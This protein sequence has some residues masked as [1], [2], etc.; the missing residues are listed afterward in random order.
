[1][2]EPSILHRCRL[3]SDHTPTGRTRHLAGG[4]VLP[5]PSELRIVQYLNDPGYYL[6]YCDDTGKELTDTYH[7]SVEG[8]MAQAE[9]E[10]EVGKH[11]WES[12]P[13]AGGS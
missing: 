6:F 9:W 5:A 2:N 4:E 3:T 8:A 1:M 13:N 12:V 7:D 10:F 11:E